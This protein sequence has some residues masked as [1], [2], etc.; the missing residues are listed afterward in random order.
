MNLEN[1][2]TELQ[3]RNREKLDNTEM[4]ELWAEDSYKALYSLLDQLTTDTAHAVALAVIGGISDY[5]KEELPSD[6]NT[7]MLINHLS[8]LEEALQDN[9]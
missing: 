5:C 8:T 4:P 9:K 2:I 7:V 6:F 3:E 1:L